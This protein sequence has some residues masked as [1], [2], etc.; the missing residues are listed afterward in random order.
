[1]L[2]YEHLR[3]LVNE[4]Q[5]ERQ[6]ERTRDALVAQAQAG[7]GER[8]SVWRGPVR[9]LGVALI[10]AGE[11]LRGPE[12]VGMAREERPTEL[13]LQVEERLRT[14]PTPATTPTV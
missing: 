3:M 6:A 2:P 7:A 1:M 13:I 11:W 12:P 4:R 9:G 5:S 10:H 8:R 14:Y